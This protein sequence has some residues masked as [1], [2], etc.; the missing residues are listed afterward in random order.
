MV[1]RKFVLP[2]VSLLLMCHGAMAYTQI[3]P[4]LDPEKSDVSYKAEN[5]YD[6]TFVLVSNTATITTDLLFR[7]LTLSGGDKGVSDSFKV[8]FNRG[9]MQ[10]YV[11]FDLYGY[12]AS[13][14]DYLSQA[15]PSYE[16]TDSGSTMIATTLGMK[17]FLN[18]CRD[19]SVALS[20]SHYQWPS[21]QYFVFNGNPNGSQLDYNE[22]IGGIDS[23]KSVNTNDLEFVFRSYKLLASFSDASDANLSPNNRGRTT[24]QAS[25]GDYYSVETP[26]YSIA[27]AKL[28][29][30]YGY[31]TSIGKEI[32][33]KITYPATKHVDLVLKGFNFIPL[34]W[35]PDSQS[36]L[37]FSININTLERFSAQSILG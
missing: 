21:A 3:A 34:I 25:W 22:S 31:W 12:N 9:P 16:I 28:K 32:D 27:Q 19:T 37:V 18:Y 20:R 2:H 11:S 13:V 23:P 36:G 29:L 15:G 35:N 17:M 1:C 5:Y 8:T 7:G 10:T 24:W 6:G 4:S 33:A 26:D 14:P 30:H